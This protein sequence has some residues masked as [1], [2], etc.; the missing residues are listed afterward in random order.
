[1]RRPGRALALGLAA[2][3]ASACAPRRPPPDR[4]LDPAGLAEQVRAAQA[5][6][7][8]VQGQ[9]RVRV[10]SPE[11]KGSVMHFLAAEKPDRVHLEALD[12]FGN[13]ALVLVA[14]AG[15]FALY[16]A[17][18]KVLW[19]G[20]ATARNL[21]RLLPI[22]LPPEDLV[23]ILCGS[24]PLLDGGAPARADPG[25]GTVTL[26]LEAAGIS[27]ALAV[28]P[29]AVVES[30][31]VRR[32]DGGAVPGA[33]DLRLAYDDAEHPGFPS[34]V[35]LDAGDRGVAIALAWREVEPNAA[36]DAAL[37]RLAPP[38]GAR[39]VDLAEGEE[40]PALPPPVPSPDG[41]ESVPRG[42][43]RD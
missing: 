10:A 16:D 32:A 27:Q 21:S 26:V 35:K 3:A 38:R 30:S 4:S 31:R 20:P 34:E 6:V 11:W 41:G 2:A 29:R 43:S 18:A 24:A 36:L 7:V 12:F 9:A 1:V 17:R 42:P 39:V 13:P 19:R 14:D 23:T 25:R 37:F 8:R 33:V 22:A 15:R 40:V 5:R 28:G